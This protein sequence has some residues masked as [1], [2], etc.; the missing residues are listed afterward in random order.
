M[1]PTKNE[2]MK[3]DYNLFSQVL[4]KLYEG[5]SITFTTKNIAPGDDFLILGYG[6]DQ[7]KV[8]FK[9]PRDLWWVFFDNDEPMLLEDCPDSFLR[10]ILKNL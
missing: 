5:L 2:K 4:G 9:R 8:S 10:S 1:A 3:R 6:Y 7:C